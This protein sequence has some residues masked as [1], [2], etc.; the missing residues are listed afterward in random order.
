M[1]PLSH[2]GPLAHLSLAFLGT[3]VVFSDLPYSSYIDFTGHNFCW[4]KK[5]F[6]LQKRLE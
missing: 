4:H 5:N 3:Y 6:G 2:I 1:G